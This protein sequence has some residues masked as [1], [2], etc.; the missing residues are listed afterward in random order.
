MVSGV[1][2]GHGRKPVL[3]V[4]YLLNLCGLTWRFC[5]FETTL[6]INEMRG[7]DGI[8]QCRLAETRLTWVAKEREREQRGEQD[9]A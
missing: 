5:C 9:M 4:R 7:E 2:Q 3:T 6:A 8:D 1:V